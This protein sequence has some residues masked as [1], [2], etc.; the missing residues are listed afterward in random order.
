MTHWLG[1]FWLEEDGQDIVEYSLLICF[2]LALLMSL[3]NWARDPITGIWHNVNGTISAANT[4]ADG[5]D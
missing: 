4:I 3:M 1:R 2:V 5:M